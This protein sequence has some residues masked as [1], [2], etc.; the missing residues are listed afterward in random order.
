ML[1]GFEYTAPPIPGR[2]ADFVSVPKRNPAVNAHRSSGWYVACP[3][4]ALELSVTSAPPVATRPRGGVLPV[5]R[6][7]PDAQMIAHLEIGTRPVPPVALRIQRAVDRVGR[8]RRVAG[9][10][11][12]DSEGV[13]VG[14][15][16]LRVERLGRE[17]VGVVAGIFDS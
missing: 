8:A 4:I 7:R 5:G 3:K 10:G 6:D 1:T 9:H 17:H 2:V 14:R 12:P 11:R 16:Q 15:L 13:G